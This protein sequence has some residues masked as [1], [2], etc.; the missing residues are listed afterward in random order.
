MDTLNKTI[1]KEQADW[2]KNKI[3]FTKVFV[4][5]FLQIKMI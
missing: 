2:P 3:K 4:D 1:H 5:I